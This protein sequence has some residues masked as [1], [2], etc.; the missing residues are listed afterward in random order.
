MQLG[1]NT[2]YIGETV[3]AVADGERGTVVS[4][5]HDRFEVQFSYEQDYAIFPLDTSN[6]RKLWPWEL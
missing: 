2:Y 6:I 5:G 1:R 3:V 4:V